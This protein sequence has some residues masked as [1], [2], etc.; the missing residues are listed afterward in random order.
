MKNTKFI[1]GFLVLIV[2]VGAY[3][4]TNKKAETKLLE[5][6]NALVDKAVDAV[7]PSFVEGLGDNLLVV[8]GLNFSTGKKTKFHDLVDKIKQSNLWKKKAATVEGKINPTDILDNIDKIDYAC[9]PLVRGQ[10]P[11]CLIKAKA[12]NDK[13]LKLLKQEIDAH[14]AKPAQADEKV[15]V[16]NPAPNKYDVKIQFEKTLLVT[17]LTFEPDRL[18]ILIGADSF[19]EFTQG[20]KLSENPTYLAV[21]NKIP[22]LP[23][24]GLTLKVDAEQMK[25]YYEMLI[26]EQTPESA[27]MLDSVYAQYAAFY[28]KLSP[29]YSYLVYDE[30]MHIISCNSN[31]ALKTPPSDVTGL[32]NPYTLLAIN[33]LPAI[34]GVPLGFTNTLNLIKNSLSGKE[35]DPK[36]M[37]MISLAEK[38]MLDISDFQAVINL[39][40][41]MAP[42]ASFILTSEHPSQLISNISVLLDKVKGEESAAPG[43]PP[44]FTSSYN[45]AEDE[46][47]I[48]ARGQTV[49]IK[50]VDDKKVIISNVAISKLT[51][52][53]N[54]PNLT[55]GVK[56]D[57][58][59]SYLLSTKL[60]IDNVMPFIGM[61]ANNPEAGISTADINEL[62]NLA[63]LE[64]LVSSGNSSE[65]GLKCINFRMDL[66]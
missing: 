51:P 58:I 31:M 14:I 32:I 46:I 2:A 63:K 16:E 12:R 18:D 20:T 61:M 29:S 28:N 34:E 64:L 6:T 40:T 33:Y 17:H 62:A 66:K 39:P 60:L 21:K 27:A 49:V 25:I 19:D 9:L 13:Y 52:L 56:K 41:V 26:N 35:Q 43:N 22:E 57:Y 50:K 65:N 5:K 4:L 42:E 44:Q 48:S 38:I 24:W 47:T 7:T 15:K 11:K 59:L 54:T 30:G 45:Q 23:A 37:E 8:G 10:S 1:F 53:L 3:L 36:V 55:L